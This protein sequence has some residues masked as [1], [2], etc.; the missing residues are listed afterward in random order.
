MISYWGVD[1]GEVAKM[2]PRE[3]PAVLGAHWTTRLGQA[4]NRIEPYQARRA[5]PVLRRLP[6]VRRAA[7]LVGN[8]GRKK[9][10]GSTRAISYDATGLFDRDQLIRD[11]AVT[12]SFVPGTGW[13]AITKLTAKQKLK[14]PG[15]QKNLGRIKPA[16][17]AYKKGMA[18][19]SRV[20]RN[21]PE[22]RDA[23]SGVKKDPWGSGSGFTVRAGSA[24]GGKSYITGSTPAKFHAGLVSHETQHAKVA[25]SDYRLGMQIKNNPQKLMREEGRADYFSAMGHY[26]DK[27]NMSGYAKIARAR[28][29]SLKAPNRPARNSKLAADT[30]GEMTGEKVSRPTNKGMYASISRKTFGRVGYKMTPASRDKSVDAYRNLHNDLAARGVPRGRKR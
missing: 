15:A 29:R 24:K 11:A 13:K 9:L 5:K 2:S 7:G 16:D 4:A 1:H 10:A 3:V 18:H 23:F 14:I 25:R 8:K 27:G 12:K 22:M 26:N 20:Y 21:D 17:K 30:Y 28:E 19:F 6:G